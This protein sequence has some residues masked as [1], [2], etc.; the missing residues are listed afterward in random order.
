MLV[1]EYAVRF[2][3]SSAPQVRKMLERE[4][5]AKD[6]PSEATVARVVKEVRGSDT[7]G[8]WDFGAAPTEELAAVVRA[9]RTALDDLLWYRRWPSRSE[10]EWIARLTQAAPDIDPAFAYHLAVRAARD[11]ESHRDIVA[12][13][14]F[15]PWTEYGSKA[16]I[17]AVV[18]GRVPRDVAYLAGLGTEVD[19]AIQTAAHPKVGRRTTKGDER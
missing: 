8:P 3:E 12:V 16:L 2:P 4:V 6:I 1:R 19:V 10:A 15:A 18:A 17:E 5:P 11:P 13:L 7:T 9:H 14:A